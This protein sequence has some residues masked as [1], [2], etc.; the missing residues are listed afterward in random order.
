MPVEVTV[1]VLN[2]WWSIYPPY[3]T[4]WSYSFLP[5]LLSAPY[6]TPRAKFYVHPLSLRR[7]KK[8]KSQ[9]NKTN[10]QTKAK[11]N[12]KTL[13]NTHTKIIVSILCWSI[14]CFWAWCLPWRV[15]VNGRKSPLEQTEFPFP[16]RCQ[17]KA[18]CLG[19]DFVFISHFPR[20]TFVMLVCVQCLWACNCTTALSG[21]AR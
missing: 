20:W 21:G 8:G 4:F 14:F 16:S 10:K 1:V 9:G 3:S 13:Q 11:K 7:E 15:V 12:V 2:W 5:K 6:S 18:T 19:W 17:L